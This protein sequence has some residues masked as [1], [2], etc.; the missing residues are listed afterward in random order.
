MISRLFNTQEP[1]NFQIVLLVYSSEQR[2][3]VYE[4][5]MFWES[6]SQSYSGVVNRHDSTM[7]HTPTKATKG[8]TNSW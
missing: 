8:S 4:P 1:S 2:L 5:A 6:G 7:E 3:F